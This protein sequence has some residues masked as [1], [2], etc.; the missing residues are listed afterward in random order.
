MLSYHSIVLASKNAFST[1]FAINYEEF[2]TLSKITLAQS[3]D[4]KVHNGN[5]YRDHQQCFAC[6]YFAP[7][8][9]HCQIFF[10]KSGVM[11]IPS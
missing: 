5:V 9:N 10:L 11:H 8:K 3:V 6:Q 4:Y 1:D 2:D 7:E